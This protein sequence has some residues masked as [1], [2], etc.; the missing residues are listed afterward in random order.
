MDDST[1]ILALI[2]LI[3]IQVGLQI[4]ALLDIYRRKTVR[5]PLPAWAW[6]VIV[7]LLSMLGPIA[8]FVLGRSEDAA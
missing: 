7:V 8:Y 2:P 3:V 6:A 5:E 4:Y 1:L